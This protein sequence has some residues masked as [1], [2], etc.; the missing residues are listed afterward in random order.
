M[1]PSGKGGGEVNPGGGAL[2]LEGTSPTAGNGAAAPYRGLDSGLAKAAPSTDGLSQKTYRSYRRRL[3]LYMKQCHRR[4][5][6][7]AIEGAFLVVSLLKDSAWEATEQLDLDEIERNSQP[8]KPILALLDTLYQYE[9]VIEVPSRCEEFFQDFVRLKGEELQAYIIRHRTMLKK[10]KEVKVD[11]PPLLAGWHLLTRAG[12]PRWTH[13]QVKSMSGGDMDYEK[14]ATAL[15]RMFGG[16]SKPNV[17]DLKSSKDEGFYEEEEE[18][19]FEE[20]WYEDDWSGWG[21]EALYEDEDYVVDAEPEEEWNEELE[22][23]ADGVEEAYVSYIESR[24]RMRDLALARGF[25]PVVALGPEAE[26][27]NRGKGDGRAKGGKGKGKRKGKGKGKNSGQRRQMPYTRRPM[28]G[29]RRSPNSNASSSTGPSEARS[30]LTGSTANHGPRFK[31]Y[32]V[33]SQGMKEVPEEQVSMVEEQLVWDASLEECY[34]STLETGQAIVDSGATRTIVGESIWKQWLERFGKP[35]SDNVKV[36]KVERSFKFGGGE[37]LKSSYEV[38]FIAGVK[39]QKLPITV[40]V[41]PGHTPFLLAR[42]TLEDWGAKHD[43]ENKSLKVRGTEWFYPNRGAKGHYILNLMEY[44]LEESL[45][46]LE[47]D[48]ILETAVENSLLQRD[49]LE[50]CWT[51]EP[52]LEAEVAGCEDEVV[53]ETE[54]EEILKITEAVLKKSREGKELIFFEVYVDEGRISHYLAKNYPEVVVSTF[55]LPEWD[56]SKAEVRKQ[57]LSLVKLVKPHFIW[58]A[59]P[60]TKWSPMQQLNMVQMWQKIK[61][62]EA[63]K[64]EERSHLSLAKDVYYECCEEDIGFGFEHPHHAASWKTDSMESMTGYLEA[65]CDRCRTGLKYYENGVCLGLVKKP[66]RVRTTLLCGRCFGSALQLPLRH[67]CAYGG[68]DKEPSGNAE[69]RARVCPSCFSGNPSGD[70][71]SLETS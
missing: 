26:K 61:I 34:F 42:P 56:F 30:T 32:R 37:V 45:H 2:A 60:C 36:K 7:A 21:Q 22:Q 52:V 23:A 35:W 28:S 68:Q 51:V 6:D 33:Q 44:P 55:S 54:D 8:F 69:L 12:I 47:E 40:S 5:R 19:D 58:M 17:K 15:M 3:E 41:V 66:T 29:L 46:V 67:S 62:L 31:R 1:P 38:S 27:G 70:G 59:P 20:E 43:F 13:V 18:V 9:D 50:D 65:V 49:A 25:Y 48:E 14:V 16:D 24:R 57:F 71:S 11:I 64:I 10:M 53:L 39:G 4:G 63:R